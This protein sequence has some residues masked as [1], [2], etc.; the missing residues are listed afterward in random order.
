VIAGVDQIA[1]KQQRNTH[2]SVPDNERECRS[3]FFGERQELRRKLLEGIAIERHSR[4][5][6]DAIKHNEQEQRVFGRL[7]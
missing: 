2:E 3:L 4:R 7:S 6:P 1:G 5:S